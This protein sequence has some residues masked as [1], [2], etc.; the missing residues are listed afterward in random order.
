VQLA[1]GGP[2]GSWRDIVTGNVRL[3]SLRAKLYDGTAVRNR[4]APS[5]LGTRNVAVPS[6][7]KRRHSTCCKF[8]VII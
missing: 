3:A 7:G 2:T 1:A 4:E 6:D 5:A 8:L